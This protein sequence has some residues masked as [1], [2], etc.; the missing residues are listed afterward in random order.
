MSPFNPY[1]MLPV[2]DEALD[3]GGVELLRAGLAKG[4]LFVTV[5]RAAFET[6]DQWGGVLADITLHLAGIYSADSDLTKDDVI[7]IVAQTFA[8]SLRDVVTS[9]PGA[10]KKARSA[11]S[12]RPKAPARAK[13]KVPPRSKAKVKAPAKMKAKANPA[14]RPASKYIAGRKGAR[15]P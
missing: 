11:K 13:A 12:A 6:P 1:D 8:R 2:A 10:A 5:R 15:K 14:S 9:S 7:A 3:R 4:E